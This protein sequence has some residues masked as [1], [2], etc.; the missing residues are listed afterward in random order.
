M[1]PLCYR[2]NAMR[3]WVAG[4]ACSPHERPA[5]ARSRGTVGRSSGLRV[6]R[7]SGAGVQRVRVTELTVPG[8]ATANGTDL[9]AACAPSSRN[10]RISHSGAR[11]KTATRMGMYTVQNI[12]KK[13]ISSDPHSLATI[14]KYAARRMPPLKL[15][16]GN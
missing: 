5:S 8:A 6:W 14:L 13:N 4:A 2:D 12:G 3:D 7:E 15:A 9:P 1:E 11:D 10:E 16:A